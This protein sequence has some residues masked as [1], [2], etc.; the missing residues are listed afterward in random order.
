MKKLLI[1]F[2]VF[3]LGIAQAQGTKPTYVAQ[4]NLVKATYYFANGKIYKQGYFQNS[5][6]TGQWIQFDKKGN[7]V[8]IGQYKAGKKVG[9]WFMYNKKKLREINY[10]NNT[11]ASVKVWKEDNTQLASN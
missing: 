9:K 8:I 5:K 2:C 11:I 10:K 3:S 6:P 7:K 4:G 1:L